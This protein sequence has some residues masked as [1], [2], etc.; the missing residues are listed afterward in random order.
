M[1]SIKILEK[2]LQDTSKKLENTEEAVKHHE[3]ELQCLK[4]DLEYFNN[5]CVDLKTAISKLTEQ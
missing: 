5:K 1:I 2:E 3:E 4:T